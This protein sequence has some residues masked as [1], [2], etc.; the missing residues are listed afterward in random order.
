MGAVD[1]PYFGT[2]YSEV[3]ISLV[4]M[5]NLNTMRLNICFQYFNIIIVILFILSI[6]NFY[7]IK[8]VI[9]IFI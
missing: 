4:F 9:I 5:L 3:W 1:Q 6:P 8:L 2:S 7:Y